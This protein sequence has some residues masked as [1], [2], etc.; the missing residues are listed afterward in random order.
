MN[1]FRALWTAVLLAPGLALADEVLL[2]PEVVLEAGVSRAEAIEVYDLVVTTLRE[3][4]FVVI[5]STRSPLGCVE[6]GIIV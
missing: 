4:A 2:V 1:L 6:P 3:N 5:D